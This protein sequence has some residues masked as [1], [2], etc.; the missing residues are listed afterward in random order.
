LRSASVA[1]HSGEQQKSAVAAALQKSSKAFLALALIS[2]I[3]NIL[4]LT[5]SVFMIQ[6]YDRVLSS[7]SLPTLTALSGGC[8]RKSERAPRGR[9]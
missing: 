1:A 8:C 3:I 9:E 5:G 7:R 6:I 4:M 2:G